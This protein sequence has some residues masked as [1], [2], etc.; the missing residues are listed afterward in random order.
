MPLTQQ[1]TGK[2]YGTFFHALLSTCPAAIRNALQQSNTSSNKKSLKEMLFKNI[3]GSS[4][5]AL[6]TWVI[7]LVA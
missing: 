5:I 7:E 1:T 3:R 2:V 6:T 4:I